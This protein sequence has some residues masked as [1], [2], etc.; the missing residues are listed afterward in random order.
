MK[1]N[2]ENMLNYNKNFSQSILRQ[3]NEIYLNQDTIMF[4]RDVKEMFN[5]ENVCI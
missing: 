4:L 3:K 5:N 2:A 1:L